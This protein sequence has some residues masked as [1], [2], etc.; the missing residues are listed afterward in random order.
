MKGVLT[1]LF[2]A[3]T[4]Q[5]L[6]LNRAN[7]WVNG[8]LQVILIKNELQTKRRWALT[9][10]P[11]EHDVSI[12]EIHSLLYSVTG[13]M[14]RVSFDLMKQPG[15]TLFIYTAAYDPVDLMVTSVFFTGLAFKNVR[16]DGLV[17]AAGDEFARGTRRTATVVLKPSFLY[18]CFFYDLLMTYL[19]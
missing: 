14:S 5:N 17:H 9:Q 19:T 6:G 7:F 15:F 16:Y 18:P 1:M 8:G 4:H 3:N 13:Q 10:P 2:Q 12:T 11:F